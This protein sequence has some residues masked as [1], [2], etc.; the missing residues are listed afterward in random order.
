MATARL[1]SCRGRTGTLSVTDGDDVEKLKPGEVRL[2]S[3]SF[4]PTLVSA[5]L[6]LQEELEQIQKNSLNIMAIK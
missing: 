6:L 5:L 4:L 3:L 1:Y 2:D